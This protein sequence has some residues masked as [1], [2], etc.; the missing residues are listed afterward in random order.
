MYHLQILD[1]FDKHGYVVK[2]SDTSVNPN[3]QILNDC[4]RELLTQFKDVFL[5]FRNTTIYISCDEHQFFIFDSHTR[6]KQGLSTDLFNATS[7]L[8]KF[9]SIQCMLGHLNLFFQS[10]NIQATEVFEATPVW[11]SGNVTTASIGNNATTD[12]YTSSQ[13]AAIQT[14]VDT[15]LFD[16][17]EVRQESITVIIAD[18]DNKKQNTKQK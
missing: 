12:Q 1:E 18:A 15:C 11:L 7:V 9:T 14:K 17:I 13:H 10:A 2:T 8:A 5:I 16:E 3:M 6:S 4:L